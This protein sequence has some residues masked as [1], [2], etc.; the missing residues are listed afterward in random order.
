MP[1]INTS[2]NL[3]N[4]D[5]SQIGWSIAPPPPF[6][7]TM[8]MPLGGVGAYGVTPMGAEGVGS[9]IADNVIGRFVSGG[10]MG[11]NG[12]GG[13]GGRVYSADRPPE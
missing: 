4:A 10:S 11:Y 5:P 13:G 1:G 2:Q 8:G 7:M 3:Q 12:Y 6:G 9:M